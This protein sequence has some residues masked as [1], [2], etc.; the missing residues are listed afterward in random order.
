[1]D[2][3]EKLMGRIVVFDC[4]TSGL[5]PEKHDIIQVAAL[6]LNSNFTPNKE[7]NP[8]YIMIK[9]RHYRIGPEYL[10][11]IKP[12]MV[13]NKL[14]I[15]KIMNDG[16]DPDK[17]AELFEEWWRS[18]GGEAVDP[19]CQNYPFDS[20]FFKAW[21]GPISFSQFFSRYY[22]DTYV[23]ARFLNDF[24]DFSNCQRPFTG[25]F[26]LGKLAKVLKIEFK[27]TQHDAFSDCLATA[28]TY[29]RMCSLVSIPRSAEK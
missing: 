20:S 1:M 11:E 22:R 28:E 7:F 26:S 21:L 9:P 18:I 24:A 13:V 14:S 29:R 27:G 25:G 17:A 8:F 6:V 2:Q 19:L 4:E 23:A 16:F 12:A 5:D 3:G 10:E 15:D